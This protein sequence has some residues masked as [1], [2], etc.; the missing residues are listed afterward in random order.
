MNS[1]FNIT[2]VGKKFLDFFGYS[3][4]EIVG[5]SIEKIFGSEEFEKFRKKLFQK[6]QLEH[7]EFQVLTKEGE[8]IPALVFCSPRKEKNLIVGYCVAFIDI[9][10]TKEKEKIL[11]EKV[12]ELEHFEKMAIGRELK[13]IELKQEIERLKGE[14]EKK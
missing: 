3:E 2:N 6:N 11:E 5:E 7:E 8:K 1:V 13:M 9:R 4:L 10:E 14:L 12:S